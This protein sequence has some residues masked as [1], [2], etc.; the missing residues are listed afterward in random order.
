MLANLLVIFFFTNLLK[1]TINS[2]FE[3]NII[4]YRN[5]EIF[6]NEL[7][8]SFVTSLIM[9]L[10]F[11]LTLLISTSDI[12]FL[13]FG[14]CTSVLLIKINNYKRPIGTKILYMLYLMQ[15]LILIQSM[16]Y[17]QK[18]DY[19]IQYTAIGG[20]LTLL[21]EPFRCLKIILMSLDEKNMW[22][23]LTLKKIV[24]FLAKSTDTF[25]GFALLMLCFWYVKNVPDIWSSIIIFS[26]N[27]LD[28]ML[29]LI[30][31]II[32]TPRI[33]HTVKNIVPKY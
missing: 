12:T 10:G 26:I 30:D 25:K 21:S 24:L 32:N 7:V 19:A 23:W 27:S 4:Y 29:R 9:M 5:E 11:A 2:N 22:I 33:K 20:I 15:L 14:F 6:L 3:Y 18:I 16:M 31:M 1:H 28:G 13:T 8:F 17:Q